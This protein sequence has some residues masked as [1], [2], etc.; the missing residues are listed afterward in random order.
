LKKRGGFFITLEGTEGA[1]KTTQMKALVKHIKSKG[2]RV[3]RTR[4][5]GGTPLGVRIRKILLGSEIRIS[6]ESETL[7]YMASRAELVRNVIMPALKKNQV[8]VSDRWM[9]ATIAYQGYGLGVN[10]R[11]IQVL[12][13]EVA[14]GV[15]PDLT[16]L[17]D[18]PVETG[19]KRAKKRGRLDRIE[20]R[21]L[22]FHKRV[23]QGYLA[24]SRS[25][26][27]IR[28]IQVTTIEE[29]REKIRKVVDRVLG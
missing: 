11:W 28:K 21:A 14:A 20:R 27:R 4:E 29:T 3:L 10:P 2:Y 25:E 15:T 17:L 24:L 22:D 1:G 6:H 23:R 16:L 26:K 5:P 8:V 12:G 7:L 19:M 13:K 18:L 9:D